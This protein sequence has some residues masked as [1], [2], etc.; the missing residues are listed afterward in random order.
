MDGVSG[1]SY[2]D[3]AD[4]ALEVGEEAPRRSAKSA[5]AF[6]TISEV[7][8]DLDVPPH[9]LRF[10]ESKFPQIKPLKRGGGRRY[11]RPEDVDLL[12]RIKELLYTSGYTIKG[13]QKLLR[14]GKATDPDD[15]AAT[16][17]GS[18]IGAASIATASL[19]PEGAIAL[20]PASLLP[21]E[22]GLD[23]EGLGDVPSRTVDSP[24]TGS[25]GLDMVAGAPVFGR[26]DGAADRHS[27]LPA[28]RPLGAVAPVVVAGQQPA[29]VGERVA[30]HRP[31]VV[32]PDPAWRDA[33]RS[34]IADLEAVR[35]SLLRAV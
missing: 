1:R 23:E 5:A 10:W 18:G 20:S 24:G 32:R 15:L 9:V 8:T 25:D 26:G 3:T 2:P 12:R 7:A 35:D 14:G 19:M 33:V 27:P 17:G 28:A 22:D 11:Y 13:V 16:A 29:M 21:D 4:A 6:R 31:E 34:A 30:A